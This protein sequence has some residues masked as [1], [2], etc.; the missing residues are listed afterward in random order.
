MNRLNVRS[1][2]YI[3][4]IVPVCENKMNLKPN[5]SFFCFPKDPIR[6]SIWIEKCGLDKNIDV[7]KRRY[8]V[9][10][11][12]FENHMFLNDLKNRL[13]PHA[14][15]TLFIDL[16]SNSL[17]STCIDNVKNDL[18]NKKSNFLEHNIQDKHFGENIN[19]F[20][21]NTIKKKSYEPVCFVPNCKA[22]KDLPLY[23]FPLHNKQLLYIWLKRIGLSTLYDMDLYLHITI[24]QIHFHK[25]CFDD[26][27]IQL[28]PNAIPSL[29]LID[30]SGPPD[31]CLTTSSY[32]EN[33]IMSTTGD[34]TWGWLGSTEQFGRDA[35]S[36]EFVVIPKS[37]LHND[38][39]TSST[40]AAHCIIYAENEEKIFGIYNAR[41]AVLMQLRYDGYLGFPG[42]LIDSGE[43]I[44]NAVNREM[45]EEM[46]LNTCIHLVS[47]DDY[48]ISHWS[49]KKKIALHF[50]KLKVTMPQLIEIEK[51]A[52]L[53]RDYGSEVLG[54]VRV[55]LYTLGDNY[56][57]FPAFLEHKFIGCSRDQLLAALSSLNILTVE[58]IN[59]ALNT[60]I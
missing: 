5:L 37:Q 6:S 8:R 47:Y 19:N 39:Y 18:D 41:A 30:Y 10:A 51:R 59:L 55:P 27:T 23:K 2:C 48:V 28:K 52:L 46:N 36:N 1:R 17:P 12:H 13:Q 60:K 45:S 31:N 50:Y 25:D 4:C 42:G 49:E 22:P 16:I 15:P 53:A 7:S 9:C 35:E 44:I 11:R 40:Q 14:I 38:K 43:D 3:E 58:E 26:K 24:C 56:R 29:H 34:R 57:G 20:F 54:T 33:P 32:F 21:P